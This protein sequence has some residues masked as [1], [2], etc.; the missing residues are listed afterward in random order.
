VIEEI[1][2]FWR[3]R[4]VELCEL[5]I[6]RERICLDAG[7]GFGKSFEENLEILRRGRDLKNFQVDSFSFPIL[8]ATSRKSTVGKVLG[9]LP[10][11]ERIFGTAATTAIAICHGADIV[12]VHDVK[13]MVQVARI[14]DATTR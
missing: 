14:C 7:F 8:S 12:R 2:E 6:S 13:E 11:E 4:V 5:G 1:C 10:P 9:D 3:A